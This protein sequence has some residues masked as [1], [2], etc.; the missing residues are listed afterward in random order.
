MRIAE[1][2]TVFCLY[3]L[4]INYKYYFFLHKNITRLFF[5]T[6]FDAEYLEYYLASKKDVIFRLIKQKITSLSC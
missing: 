6:I 1:L 3:L 4:I 5:G 2:I